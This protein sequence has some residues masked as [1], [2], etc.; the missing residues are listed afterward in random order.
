VFESIKHLLIKI[1]VLLTS[2]KEEV[3]ITL[4]IIF[5]GFGSYGLG[6]LAR[7]A[8]QQ[9]VVDIISGSKTTNIDTDKSLLQKDHTSNDSSVSGSNNGIVVASKSGKKYHFPWCA[10]AKQIA[11]KNKI[12]F[13]STEEARRAG[14]TPAV[15]C[16]GLE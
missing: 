2:I 8:S 16:K 10:G 12:T 9:S 1:K 15:N 4:I 14:Y 3:L 6:W 5:V 11:E 7:G 13:N